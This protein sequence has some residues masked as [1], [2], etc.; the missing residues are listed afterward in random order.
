MIRFLARAAV[1]C[2]MLSTVRAAAQAPAFEPRP[3]PPAMEGARC[4]TV[5][6]PENRDA[7]RRMLALNVVVLPARSATPAR[8]A[9][10]FFGGGPGQAV[11]E[12]APWVAPLYAPLRDERDLL[13]IDQ[14]GTGGSAPLRCAL[15]DSAN[16]QSYLDDF[17]PPAAAARCRQ[18]L[19]R[20]A[21]LTRY[22]YLELAHDV[23]AVR[24]A[25]GYERLDLNGGS[26]GTRAALVYLRTYP[27]NVRSVLL[28]GVIPPEAVPPAEWARDL[29]ASLA[30]LVAD[31]RAEPACAAAFPDPEGE[32]RAV[33]DRLQARPGTAEIVDPRSG[34]RLRLTLSRGTFIETIRRML[35]DP[36]AAASLPWLVHRAYQGD[37]RPVASAAL[38]DRR[39]MEESASM[40][41]FL[42]V[43]CGEDVPFIDLAAAAAEN[44][45]TLGGDY[46]V[47]QHVEAC[48]GWPR[49]ALPADYHQPVRFDVPV[50]LISG[51]LDPATPPR[52]GEMAAAAFPNH[53]H[54]VVPHA[55][56]AYG[57]MEGAACVDSIVVRFYR[58]GSV[59]GLDPSC[60]SNVR[61]PPFLIEQP[62]P[63]T[64][65]R[66]AVARFTGAFATAGPPPMD[67]RVEALDGVL[68]ATFG[69]GPT[70]IALPISATTFRWEG[71]PPGFLFEFSE[72]GRTLTVRIPGQEPA[73]LTRTE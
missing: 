57:G 28:M 7:P 40:G 23:E 43:T 51:A 67:V 26:Y 66:A 21:E 71:Y 41:L 55:G 34:A 18:E 13:F 25:L 3:C 50:L 72:D 32:A 12:I 63:I 58:Q 27:R 68:R 65:D 37:Y 44:E 49:Y 70:V 56:H 19:S 53:L 17:L 42:A 11:T 8:E 33:A 52:S 9:I 14:R 35:Y 61:R 2:V 36:W 39:M 31:C 64:L 5:R 48:R 30:G 62:E 10:T 47:R 15:R 38:Q 1:A 46:R 24:T 22:G 4:G 60:V 45:R 20:T 29:D 6:V 59:R 69:D 73:T 54:V 16:P